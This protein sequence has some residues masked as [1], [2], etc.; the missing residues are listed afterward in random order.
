M[1]YEISVILPNGE[2]L[3]VKKKAKIAYPFCIICHASQEKIDA[4]KRPYGYW[5]LRSDEQKCINEAFAI[6]QKFSDF[7]SVKCLPTKIRL[8]K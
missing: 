7:Q 8:I 5:G 1:K 4:G 2:T 3:I 6:A